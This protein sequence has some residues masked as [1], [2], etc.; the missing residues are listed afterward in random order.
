METEEPHKAVIWF[1]VSI[2]LILLA[3]QIAANVHFSVSPKFPVPPNYYQNMTIS[4]GTLLND[5]L[6]LLVWPTNL[7]NDS[8]LKV[9]ISN[10]S[11]NPLK[12]EILQLLAYN[13]TLI[14]PGPYWATAD[15]AGALQPTSVTYKL[16]NVS[17]YN[18]TNITLYHVELPFYNTNPYNTTYPPSDNLTVYSLSCKII[19]KTSVKTNVSVQYIYQ[20]YLYYNYSYRSGNNVYE[21][22][23]YNENVSGMAYLLSNNN[24]INSS[25]F[26]LTFWYY[27]GKVTMN[28]T[29][30]TLVPPG[31]YKQ[32]FAL[33]SISAS[34]EKY[35]YSYTQGNYTYYVYIFYPSTPNITINSF[36]FNWYEYEVTVPVRIVVDNGTCPIITQIGN[37][38]YTGRTINVNFTFT[39]WSSDPINYTSPDIITYDHI[40]I[41]NYTIVR[42]WIAGFIKIITTVYETK[43]GN[44]IN[45]Y[46]HIQVNTNIAKQPE[47]VFHHIPKEEVYRHNFALEFLEGPAYLF[48]LNKYLTNYFSLE[49]YTNFTVL[50]FFM[51]VVDSIKQTNSTKLLQPAVILFNYSGPTWEVRNLNLYFASFS[52][53]WLNYSISNASIGLTGPLQVPFNQTRVFINN[54]QGLIITSFEWGFVNISKIQNGTYTFYRWLNWDSGA[55]QFEQYEYANYSV[56]FLF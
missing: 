9:F 55:V 13:A 47:W 30:K 16:Y 5:I 38:T 56:E 50:S 29:G 12:Q 21:Y 19:N 14:A 27:G 51:S 11:G 28:I 44:T 33:Y 24:I 35:N 6:Q 48:G 3:L 7:T 40:T 43:Q 20:Y 54:Q 8:N 18:G 37:K 26:Q 34:E 23:Y 45:Y 39:V 17:V 52:L 4:S 31:V 46:L 32:V 22:Y 53:P 36:T 1:V 2:L 10:G 49:K 25:S 15:L 42:K 41:A